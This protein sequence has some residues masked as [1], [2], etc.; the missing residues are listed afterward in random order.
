MILKGD[1]R[2]DL[3]KEIQDLK[4]LNW[5]DVKSSPGTPG[6]FLK[7]YEETN[8]ERF[9]YKLSNY[10]SYRGV[11]G[12]ECVN[13]LIISRLLDI[14]DIEHLHY[15][16]IHAAILI[17]GREIETYI[18]KS[19]NFRKSNE[20]KIAFDTYYDLHKEPNESPLDFAVRMG[21]KEYIYQMIVID[22][23]ICNRDRHG[24]NIELLVDEKDNVRP[25]PLFDHGVS[26]LFSCYDNQNSI[27]KFDVMEDRVVQNFIGSKSLEY[28]LQLLPK[29]KNLFKRELC[30]EDKEKLLKDLDGIL[31]SEHLAKIW[32]MIWKRWNRYV[33]ICN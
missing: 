3:V 6:C 17:D 13:E 2:M 32:D 33:Q 8:G 25:A 11:F 21:W 19:A 4:Y 23:L 30:E 24:A 15:Q 20:R 27:Q 12:H 18:N 7:A 28:N 10:D 26:L 29:D 31:S 9:Y 1:F 5:T 14:F 16:L 22:Y